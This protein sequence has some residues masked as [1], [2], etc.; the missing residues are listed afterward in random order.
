MLERNTYT[1]FVTD[2]D[3]ASMTQCSADSLVLLTKE[4]HIEVLPLGG[5]ISLHPA[6]IGQLMYSVI[7]DAY[8]VIQAVTDPYSTQLPTKTT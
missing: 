6:H 3:V 1:T 7:P 8:P 5:D 2:V 4:N